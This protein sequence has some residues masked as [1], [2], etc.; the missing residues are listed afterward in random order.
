MRNYDIIVSGS[1]QYD[2]TRQKYVNTTYI[3][4]ICLCTIA[5]WRAKKL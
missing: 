4:Y 5:L 2:T 1:V 3:L